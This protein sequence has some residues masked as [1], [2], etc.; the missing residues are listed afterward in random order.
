MATRGAQEK[1]GEGAQGARG[2]GIKT[3][4]QGINP[5][6]HSS[7]N[8]FDQGNVAH[9][10][11]SFQSTSSPSKLDIRPA[12]DVIARF[13][14]VLSSLSP[15]RLLRHL[16]NALFSPLLCPPHLAR[17]PRR[18]LSVFDKGTPF[19]TQTPT[20]LGKRSRSERGTPAPHV[21]SDSSLQD[22]LI[23]VGSD[24]PVKDNS[25]I[26]RSRN[27]TSLCSIDISTLCR[28]LKRSSVKV[29]SS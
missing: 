21:K 22:S 10:S 9:Q 8:Q 16:G 5:F 25:H 12:L 23:P 2:R 6:I 4:K 28:H 13:I 29:A 20:Y 14:L 19:Q 7:I 18:R 17:T 15:G 1:E 24:V 27:R 3:K 11:I 26:S